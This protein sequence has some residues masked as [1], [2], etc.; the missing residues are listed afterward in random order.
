M[1]TYTAGHR[2][3]A[4]AS[5]AVAPVTSDNLNA[6]VSV[7]RSS[8]D[9]VS[10][11]G[12]EVQYDQSQQPQVFEETRLQ[13]MLP[14]QSSN[15]DLAQEPQSTATH[16]ETW[17]FLKQ[18]QPTIEQTQSNQDHRQDSRLAPSWRPFWLTPGPLGVLALLFLGSAIAL[19]SMLVY[20]E[21]YDGLSD[22]NHNLV[23]L[24]RFGPTA[25]ESP[26]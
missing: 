20:S 17:T 19:I 13:H 16:E 3:S 6:F 4:D 23:Y 1:H 12:S 18:A 5:P 7:N 26:I 11:V 2:Q 22:A 25:C 14:R 15:D 10:D 21:V 24:W 9:S 8:S